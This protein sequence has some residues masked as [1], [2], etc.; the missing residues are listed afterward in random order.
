MVYPFDA[1]FRNLVARRFATFARTP[2]S[3]THDLKRADGEIVA[4]VRSWLR[5]L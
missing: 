3:D 2:V 5:T 1:V 4:T